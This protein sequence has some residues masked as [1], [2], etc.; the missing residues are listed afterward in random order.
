M[1]VFK[2]K[3]ILFLINFEENKP[4]HTFKHLFDWGVSNVPFLMKSMKIYNFCDNDIN[5]SSVLFN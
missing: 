1:I 5:I 2:K 4:S 3:D